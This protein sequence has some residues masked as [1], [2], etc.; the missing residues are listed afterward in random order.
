MPIAFLSNE[1]TFPPP[2]QAEPDGLLAIGGDLSV[3]RLRVAYRS[4]IFPWYSDGQPI[5]WFSPDP[6]MVLFPPKL[7][8]SRSLARVLASDRFRIT[9]DHDFEEVITQCKEVRR[10]GQE[11]TW[12]TDA[13]KQAYLRLHRAGFAHSVEV[14]QG[15]RLVG[16]LYGVTTGTC[17][18]GES[19][20]AKVSDASKVG[21][22]WLVNRLKEEG[23]Q[24]VD[25][26]VWTDHLARFGAELMPRQHFLSLL[27][28]PAAI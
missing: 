24:M 2:D 21:F 5:L 20:F 13:M 10:P 15:D 22:V 6:R 27:N 16:G 1:L 4:G 7:H 23:I 9:C 8:V 3:E 17:F 18:S 19:M 26:Q 25:C 28:P 14:W 12:V 11:G